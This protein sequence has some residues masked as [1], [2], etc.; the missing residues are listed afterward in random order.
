MDVSTKERIGKIYEALPRMD[1]GLCGFESCGKFARAVAEG[2]ASPFGCR[3][4]PW[5]G[6]TISEIVG[7]EVP[8]YRYGLQ[9]ASFPTLGIGASPEALGQEIRRLSKQVDDI[10]VRIEKLK[11]RR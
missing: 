9:P 1:C 7:L 8:S 6:Y 4:N 2:R 10:L 5:A 3:Q 11:A